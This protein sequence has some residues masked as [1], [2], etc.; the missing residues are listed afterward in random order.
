MTA[1]KVMEHFKVVLEEALVNV[2]LESKD[3]ITR[4][5]KVELGYLEPLKVDDDENKDFPYVLIRYINGEDKEEESEMNL[6]LIIGVHSPDSRG[7]VDILHI[8]EGI[9]QYLLKKKVFDYYTLEHPV[10]SSIPEE[11]AY[12]HFHGFLEL[13]FK[14]PRIEIEG[15]EEPWL[16]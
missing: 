1:Y 4:K 3:N 6:K 16:A 9:K 5:P 7:W 10:K 8:I 13:K 15:V 14:I 11:Q 12:P 2:E